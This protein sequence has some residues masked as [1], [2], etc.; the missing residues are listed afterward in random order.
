MAVCLIVFLVYDMYM[1]G[2]YVYPGLDS[3]GHKA[4]WLVANLPK[5]S[6]KLIVLKVAETI[7]QSN[8]AILVAAGRINYYFMQTTIR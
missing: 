2:T 4:S 1:C 5:L 8:A 7:D 3:L 6:L